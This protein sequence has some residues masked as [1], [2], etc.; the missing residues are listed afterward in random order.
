MIK[1]VIFDYFGV[2]ASAKGHPARVDIAAA[3]RVSEDETRVALG[4][5][6]NEF[7]NGK[8]TE[9][10]FWQRMAKDLGKPIPKNT[11]ELWRK[12]FGEK[13]VFDEKVVNFIKSLKHKE[14]KIA[15]LS[16]TL[17]PWAEIVRKRGG[18]DVFDVVANSCE[19]GFSKPDVMAYKWVVKKL[20]EK[21]E[22]ILFV[23][24]KGE[25]LEPA[26]KLKMQTL[27][28]QNSEQVIKEVSV[29]IRL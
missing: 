21:P 10:E 6:I 8:V 3:F 11:H 25:N 18:F 4:K 5:S 2:V 20:G 23:D 7:R 22:E 12:G 27:L 24:D 13:L 28:A 29:L 15:V 1:A 17:P 19:T 14:I 9:D 16:N 26:R